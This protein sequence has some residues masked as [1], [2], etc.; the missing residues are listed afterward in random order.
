M[1]THKN[2]FTF[3][4]VVK[5]ADF[6][7]RT[8]EIKRIKQLVE[9]KNNLIIIS[10]R[11]YGKT[12]LII[13]ALERNK[14]KFIFVDCSDLANEKIFLERL[15][16]A[17]LERLNEGD[18]MDKIKMLSKVINLE[19]SFNVKGLSITVVKYSDESL[20]KLIKEISKEY[21][22]VFDEFQELF[23][24]NEGLVKRLRSILQMIKQSF[25]F[26]GSKKHLLLYLFSNQKSAFYNFG[27][28]LPLEKIPEEEWMDFIKKKFAKNKSDINTKEIHELLAYAGKI[29][30][31]VQY[32]AYYFWEEKNVDRNISVKRTVEKILM[33]NA[34][35]YEE[36]YAK[37]P[38]MQ[39]MALKLLLKTEEKIFSEHVLK[40]F[41]IKGAQQ[42][43]KALTL[44][45]DKGII[46]RNGKYTFNDPFF[47]SYIAL[48]PKL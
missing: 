15:T 14:V 22:I 38:T 27:S 10:P 8:E 9:S 34:Y 45:E 1:V 42:L 5:G 12:S 7:N 43:N 3:G 17:Y 44:L 6:C 31:Y 39:K 47:K 37:L 48:A 21:V 28:I 18:L 13:N 35:V 40:S 46:E 24:L 32:L 29:P 30:F 41:N 20:G 36:L 11:R 16:S 26:L 23:I 2:P 25:I 19:Y 33:S 4:K